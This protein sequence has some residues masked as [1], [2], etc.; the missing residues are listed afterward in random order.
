MTT[1]KI[2]RL[3][4]LAKFVNDNFDRDYNLPFAIEIEQHED[5]WHGVRYSLNLTQPE[6]DGSPVKTLFRSKMLPAEFVGDRFTRLEGSVVGM[7]SGIELLG[8]VAWYWM[9]SGVNGS[10]RELGVQVASMAWDAWTLATAIF[11]GSKARDLFERDDF[12]CPGVTLNQHVLCE[13]FVSIDREVWLKRRTKLLDNAVVIESRWT[14][15]KQYIGAGG[16]G[17]EEKHT[18]AE[19][20]KRRQ[21]PAPFEIIFKAKSSPFNP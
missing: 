4:K 5:K 15:V 1:R 10:D 21:V 16:L 14:F 19:V 18:V 17:H 6:C 7:A 9:L 11:D 8:Q 13:K 20:T 12:L 2:A 3:D